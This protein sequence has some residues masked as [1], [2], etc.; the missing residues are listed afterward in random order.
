MPGYLV[1]NILAGESVTGPVIQLMLA[2]LL[3]L[4]LRRHWLAWARHTWC[5]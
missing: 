3:F 2:F 5:C 1:L 4:V